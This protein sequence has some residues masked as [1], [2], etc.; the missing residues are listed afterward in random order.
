MRKTASHVQEYFRSKAEEL[1]AAA[2]QAVAEPAPRKDNP[3][4]EAVRRYLREFLPHGF[5][6]TPL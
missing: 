5:S 6:C 4:A 1:R 3:R 2:G